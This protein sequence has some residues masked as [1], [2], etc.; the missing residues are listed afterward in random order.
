MRDHRWRTFSASRLASG[1]QGPIHNHG[2]R[3]EPLDPVVQGC[4][5][6]LLRIL[7]VKPKHRSALRPFDTPGRRALVGLIARL[8]AELVAGIDVCHVNQLDVVL[9]YL[10][11]TKLGATPKP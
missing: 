3:N 1:P 6:E 9:L 8:N 11:I 10:Q 5:Q 7:V 2:I 4:R